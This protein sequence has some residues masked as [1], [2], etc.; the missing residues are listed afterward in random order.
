MSVGIYIFLVKAD[1]EAVQTLKGSAGFASH[2]KPLLE[3]MEKFIIGE[4]VGLVDGAEDCVGVLK[5][6]VL[7]Y[8]YFIV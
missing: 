1:Q 5:V 4:N 8:F 7:H 6:T 2:F 3:F